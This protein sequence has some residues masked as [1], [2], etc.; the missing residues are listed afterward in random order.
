M[1]HVRCLANKA[2]I[3]ST[4]FVARGK[5]LCKFGDKETADLFI[6]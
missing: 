1:E 4:V 5:V 2:G 3:F 6:A